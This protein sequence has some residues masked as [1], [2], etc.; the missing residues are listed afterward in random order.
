MNSATYQTLSA[1]LHLA[2]VD[3]DS[4]LRRW[5]EPHRTWHGLGHLEALLDRIAEL[6][7][8]EPTRHHL[9]LTALYHDIIYDPRSQ[10]NEE[11]S[12]DLFRADFSTHTDQAMVNA[13]AEAILSTKTGA[14]VNELGAL[15]N[16]LDRA[17]LHE[18]SLARLVAY[19]H[20]ILREYQFASWPVYRD[21]R[22]E[23][24]RRVSTQPEVSRAY[25]GLTEY[26]EGYR[27]KI[28]LYAGSFD[29]FHT[30][31]LNIVEKAERLFDKVIIAVGINPDK[32]SIG[33]EE[34]LARVRATLPFH[35][36]ISFSGLLTHLT[37]E[38][39]E[40][41]DATLVRG[42]RDGYDLEYELNQ[43][44]FM[45]DL[46]PLVQIVYLSCDREFQHV[47]S[48]SVRALRRFDPDAAAAYLPTK[49]AYAT[50]AH[51]NGRG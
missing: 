17:I 6:D 34:R 11:G 29:P 2:E 16:P 19:E 39:E 40:Y 25:Q 4:L 20:Q 38:I 5:Q 46:E 37:H 8:E 13:V 14:A 3:L 43:A 23:F 48:R 42:L 27:P 22:L 36:V 10:T 21:K 18:Q 47:S 32:D 7:V 44:Q 15:F 35:E 45:K 31:H 51:E 33:Q 24:L 12:A 9:Q 50:T 26:V 28:A 49:F 41:A 1:N 30:G